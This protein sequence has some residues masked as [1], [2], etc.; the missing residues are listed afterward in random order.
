MMQ[1]YNNEAFNKWD[2]EALLPCKN[3]QRTFLP[4]RL[5]IHNKSCLPGRPLKMRIGVVQET[6]AT[7][8]TTKVNQ[9]SNSKMAQT[10]KRYPIINENTYRET[11]STSD[12]EDDQKGF[13]IIRHYDPREI[14]M[15]ETDEE[16]EEIANLQFGKTLKTAK[17]AQQSRGFRPD[18]GNSFETDYI[19]HTYQQHETQYQVANGGPRNKIV[20]VN[21]NDGELFPCRFCEKMLAPGK[22]FQHETKCDLKPKKLILF[23]HAPI[24]KPVEK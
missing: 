6:K 22:I 16:E 15:T 11:F 21:E 19:T 24:R 2:T 5:I 17:R 12:E 9:N 7:A 10:Q 3:C 23:E 4:D 8:P 18:A 20:K 14:I 13:Q 1:A